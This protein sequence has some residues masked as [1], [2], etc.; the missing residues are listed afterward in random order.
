MDSGDEDE[1]ADRI[2]SNFVP[3]TA[4]DGDPVHFYK[5]HIRK[6]KMFDV[7]VGILALGSSFRMAARQVEVAK[8]GLSL[9]YLKGCNRARV[10]FCA[11]ATLSWIRKGNR[12]TRGAS[13]RGRKLQAV[14][15]LVRR[16]SA[17]TRPS[18]V[19]GC[20]L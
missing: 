17:R 13:C 18:E 5:I 2:L 1:Q 4:A 19:Y 11:R 3:V 12:N 10:S 9:G 14:L 20:I 7:E 8:S 15:V 6:A 16:A